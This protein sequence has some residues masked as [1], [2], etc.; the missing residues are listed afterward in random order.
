MFVEI[1]IL[2]G[3]GDRENLKSVERLTIIDSD[4]DIPV[5]PDLEE[6]HDDYAS[7]G[8]ISSPLAVIQMVKYKEADTDFL[9]NSVF[10]GYEEGILR[11]LTKGMQPES[12][13]KEDDKPMTWQ[14][15]FT[16]I[17]LDEET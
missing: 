17:S 11:L 10:S 9:K 14:E 3:V 2:R 4:D 6:M 12:I 7:K 5:I 8:I 1:G 13:I 15:L 16:K